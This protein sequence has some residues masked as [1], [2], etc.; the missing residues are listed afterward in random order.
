MS[1]VEAG[2]VQVRL[3]ADTQGAMKGFNDVVNTLKRIEAQA[4]ETQKVMTNAIGKATGAIIANMKNMNT[5]STTTQTRMQKDLVKTNKFVKD[6]SIR[7]N[8]AY[9]TLF[10]IK[11]IAVVALGG[12][13][14]SLSDVT[15]EAERMKASLNV[16][17]GGRGEETFTALSSFAARTNVT[18]AEA[19]KQ[20]TQLRAV[21]LQPTIEDMETLLDLTNAFGGS[22]AVFQRISKALGDIQAKGKLMGEEVRQLTNIGVPI[23]AI[24]LESGLLAENMIDQIGKANISATKV[25]QAIFDYTKKNFKGIT[26]EIMQTWAG[27]VERLQDTWWRWRR[28]VAETG[29]IDVLK[30]GVDNLIS[31][32]NMWLSTLESI[33]QQLK[34]ITNI[35]ISDKMS[36]SL[37]AIYGIVKGIE[38]A[39]KGVATVFQ[40]LFDVMETTVYTITDSI[41]S[42]GS[43]LNYLKI[44]FTEGKDAADKFAE[45]QKRIKN[46][47]D[48]MLNKEQSSRISSIWEGT[49]FNPNDVSDKTKEILGVSKEAEEVLN[50]LSKGMQATP[51]TVFEDLNKK[52]AATAQSAT[53]KIEK[54]RNSLKE[55]KDEYSSYFA[56]GGGNDTVLASLQEAMR[57]AIDPKQ[58]EDIRLQIVEY[59]KLTEVMKENAKVAF[60]SMEQDIAKEQ[61]KSLRESVGLF[62]Q[63]EKKYDKIVGLQQT[64]TQVTAKQVEEWGKQLN[65]L[66]LKKPQ[67]IQDIQVAREQLDLIKIKLEEPWTNK[68][69]D[70]FKL[71]S[72]QLMDLG[73]SM[74]GLAKNI[75]STLTDAFTEFF[76][77]GKTDWF[78]FLQ[79]IRQMI[80]KTLV[81]QTISGPLANA[82]SMAIKGIGSYFGGTPTI[83][84]SGQGVTGGN[85]SFTDA[86]YIPASP[87]AD[88]GWINEPV[89]G[90]G[91]KSGR[92]YSFAER[93]SEYVSSTSSSKAMGGG[94]DVTVN[95][96]G[97]D[98]NTRVRQKEGQNGPEIDIYLDKKMAQL[99]SGGSATAKALR[100]SYGLT[101]R[102]V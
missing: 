96:Y 87:H 2:S 15:A 73:S 8:Q 51:M 74:E 40:T 56:K 29:F 53:P 80:L 50:K 5:V 92:A 30:Q 52:I 55:L 35:V 101:Q 6:L 61:A 84:A 102:R 94:S 93:G 77:K 83:D 26:Q 46:T 76:D 34:T 97:G 7:F 79:T 48:D 13:L 65:Q 99:V 66:S 41:L 42:A 72:E 37:A 54:M 38:V 85:V 88:G 59:Q 58:K 23:R 14:K 75:T 10:N 39:V 63:I 98:E 27:T 4:Y 20:Y 71:A 78:S 16:M 91:A 67:L 90:Y 64:E 81:E 43:K 12:M 21:G 25:I 22:Q 60:S 17:T 89:Y 9:R 86:S 95:I 44:F 69:A 1:S 19:V 57:T 36:G 24:L 82:M 45:S 31:S 28:V 18:T 62:S 68:L 33:G 70:G 100:A 32:N 49:K 47:F 11:T 3:T